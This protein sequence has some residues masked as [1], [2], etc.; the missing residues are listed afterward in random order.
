MHRVYLVNLLYEENEAEAEIYKQERKILLK[1]SCV[2]ISLSL[3][4][5]VIG[6]KWCLV[7]SAEVDSKLWNLYITKHFL[8]ISAVSEPSIDSTYGSLCSGRQSPTNMSIKSAFSNMSLSSR[9][10]T[11]SGSKEERT[12]M[13]V[14]LQWDKSTEKPTLSVTL[15][16]AS[17]VPRR[18]YSSHR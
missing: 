14:S 2:N 10:T 15:L 17:N 8:T 9:S 12:N 6:D 16:E 13:K 7:K 18:S 4:I 1:F 11:S 3:Q 5:K